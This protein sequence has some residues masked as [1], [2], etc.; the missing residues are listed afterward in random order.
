MNAL[1]G[2]HLG[3]TATIVGLGPSILDLTADHFPPGPVIAI[4]HAILPIRKLGLPNRIYAM[5]KDGCVPHGEFKH[6]PRFRTVRCICP[7]PRMVA[8]IEPEELLLSMAESSMCF[9]QYL[10]RHVFDCKADF[11]VSW[12][13]MSVPI[14]AYI[15]AWMGC[16]AILMLGHDAYTKG[17]ARRADTSV[18]PGNL[19]GYRRASVEAGEVA[20]AAGIAIVW[21]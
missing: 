13:T 15:A 6:S 12:H 16:S 9:R 21:A 8:P 19:E 10:R 14:A 2:V 20:R 3:E 4:N 5:Q 11:G 17:D 1:H 18:I 7:S